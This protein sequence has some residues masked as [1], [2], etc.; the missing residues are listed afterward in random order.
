VLTKGACYMNT[1]IYV[2]ILQSVDGR[3]YTGCCYELAI[4]LAKYD[5]Y[6]KLLSDNDISLPA[7]LVHHQKFKTEDE[8]REI[9]N[10]I[11][12]WSKKEKQFLINNDW[13]EISKLAKKF[14]Y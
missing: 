2:Y 9:A 4:V 13:H 10:E 8:A 1:Q 3:Y 6:N 14:I 5:K 11:K 7:K 12:Q